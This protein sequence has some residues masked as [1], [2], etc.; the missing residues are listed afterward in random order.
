MRCPEYVDSVELAIRVLEAVAVTDDAGV[1][2]LARK[3]D[4]PK[5]TVQRALKT[6]HHLEWLAPIQGSARTRWKRG[7]KFRAIPTE[8]PQNALLRKAALRPM[9]RLR[10]ST[11]ET[12]HLTVPDGRYITIIERLDSPLPLQAVRPVGLRV[13]LHACSNGKNVLAAMRAEELA[14]YLSSPLDGWTRHTVVD[15]DTLSSH[16]QA[17]C[18][19]GYAVNLEETWEGFRAV[20]APIRFRGHT[21]ASVS[22]SCPSARLPASRQSLFGRRIVETAAEISTAFRRLRELEI[23]AAKVL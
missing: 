20:A 22:L 16:I 1:S 23:Q 7:N 5:T 12:T 9:E 19:Q 3:L 8:S 21:I 4:A 17:T 10:Q 18:T 6:L 11:G 14:E 13:P 2:E 15:A